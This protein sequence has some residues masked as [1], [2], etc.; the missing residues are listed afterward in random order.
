TLLKGALFSEFADLAK[1]E[2]MTT[3]APAARIAKFGADYVAATAKF[4]TAWSY[5]DTLVAK[6]DDRNA[7]ALRMQ[8]EIQR[9]RDWE[10]D[11]EAETS[12]ADATLTIRI[13]G[14]TAKLIDTGKLDHYMN[15]ELAG[16]IILA[17]ASGGTSRAPF[18]GS[19]DRFFGQVIQSV[20]P[21]QY[22]SPRDAPF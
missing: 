19:D 14:V 9:N 7:L 17:A 22:R 6:I 13:D 4:A 2:G 11:L 16:E 15:A 20:R 10:R 5:V 3:V 18:S 8:L 21:D 12:A 1:A